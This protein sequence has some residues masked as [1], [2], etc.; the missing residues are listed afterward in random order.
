MNYEDGEFIDDQFVLY[1]GLIKPDIVIKDRQP[2]RITYLDRQFFIHGFIIFLEPQQR[3][4]SILLLGI[5]P[6]QDDLYY[7]CLPEEKK[8][9]KFTETYFN[10]LLRNIKTYYYDDA[11]FIPNFR[12]VTFDDKPIPH[13]SIKVND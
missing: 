11:H 2:F 6:N 1:R 8:H 9:K 12:L 4:D 5:H 7:Y 10:L 3:V 13:M